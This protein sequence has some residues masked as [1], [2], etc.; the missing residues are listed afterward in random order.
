MAESLK[1]QVAKGA[2]WATL[3]K[4][5][6]QVVNF[7]VGM[8]LARLLTPSDY[9]TVALLSIFFAIASSLA[10]C[11]F[12]NAL[13]QRKY[14]GDLE[15][16]SVFYVSIAASVLIYAV[17]FFSAPVIAAFYK[18]PIL[19][20]LTRVSAISFILN[21]INSVQGAE[22]SRKMLFDRRFR[23]NLIVCVV[24][25]VSGV[26]FAY[27]GFGVWSL[28]YSSLL[29]CLARV[30]A[31][32]LIIA[33]RPKM[34][35]SLSVVKGLFSYGWKLSLSS[36]IN[37]LYSELYGFLVGRV[38]TPADLAFVNKS[39]SMPKLLMTT[40]NDTIASVSF[41]ALA[42]LQDDLDKFRNAVRRMIQCSTFVVFPLL[43]MLAMTAHPLTLL[44]Y[45]H[46]WEP[47]VVYVPIGCVALAMG[48]I[49]SINCMA[50]SAL[51][52]SGVFLVLECVKKV[53]GVSLMLLSIRHGVMAFIMTM[54]FVQGPLTILANT[55]VN[56]R[57]IR[58]NFWMQMVDILPS[59]L[60]CGVMAL[61][62]MATRMLLS[63]ILNSI[64]CRN[65][66]FGIELGTEGLVG[67]I[68]Y[69]TLAVVLKLRPLKEYIRLLLPMFSKKIPYLVGRISCLVTMTGRD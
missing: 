5:S 45:G 3:E 2:V 31:Y 61:L 58:Y 37:T 7:V 64:A 32:W 65:I 17:F 42:K 66:A 54:A 21:A 16:N 18:V 40:V 49:T 22:L 28:V 30:T 15:F 48:P 33:W 56:G 14:V 46:Q 10:S 41:P 20:P 8:V 27:M 26:S 50:I 60:L 6:T 9:G 24:S 67:A 19:C 4:F 68:S 44:L 47:A 23:I 69:I 53:F 25:A 51:G 1:K 35:F 11:G 43:T 52:R 62:M 63:P 57:L 29:A 38:Y 36:M 59:I 39:R 34:M 13:V 55:Y 12:G